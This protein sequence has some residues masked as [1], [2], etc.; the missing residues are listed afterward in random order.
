MEIK[1][2]VA[3]SLFLKTVI[4]GLVT[5]AVLAVSFAGSVAVQ[6]YYVTAYDWPA[7]TVLPPVP[8]EKTPSVLGSAYPYRCVFALPWGTVPDEVKLTPG[9]GLQSSAEPRL[10]R[11]AYGWGV[12][13]YTLLFDLQAYRLE[14]LGES[15]LAVSFR[16]GAGRLCPFEFKIPPPE[17]ILPDG[18]N[19][20]DTLLKTAGVLEEPAGK[21]FS[22][23]HYIVTAALGLFLIVLI[24]FVFR[25]LFKRT[26]VTPPP[27]LQDVTLESIRVLA[28]GVGNR[29]LAPGVALAELSNIVRRYLEKRFSIPAERRTTEEFFL[30]VERAD[31]PLGR[32]D[33]GFLKGFLEAADMVKFARMEATAPLFEQASESAVR[34][35][36]NSRPADVSPGVK[37]SGDEK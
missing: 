24:L 31:S 13:E 35:V 32:E 14:E 19:E 1:K 18:D 16:T 7:E 10:V 5:F 27:S 30:G 26:F 33:R 2:N 25:D 23:V 36:E 12:N 11:T 37:T 22:A 20:A 9:N 17:V 6:Y 34:L 3:S 21:G 8:E 28:E 15:V 4:W 29:S